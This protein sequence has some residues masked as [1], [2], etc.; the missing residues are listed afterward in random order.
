MR[1]L[2][3]LL[4]MLLALAGCG[5]E[6]AD[7]P[8][9]D[10]LVRLLDAEVR[11]LDPQKASDLA[12]LR[13]A[14]DQFEGLTRLGADGRVEAGLARQWRPS[15]DGL[16]WR[17]TLRPGLAFSDGQPITAAVFARGFARLAEGA[18]GSPHKALFGPVAAVT[19]TGDDVV[20]V[21]LNA[22]FPALP[23]LMAHPA[24]AALPLHRGEGWAGERP[25]TA[26][27]A[28]RLTRWRLND[29]LVLERNP[30]WHDGAA[31]VGHVLWRPVDDRQTAF[32]LFRAG[33]A[34]T[35]PDFPVNRLDWLKRHRPNAVRMAPYRG[36]YYFVF[37]TRRPPF[38]DARVRR[39]LNMA[40]ERERIA[41]PLLGFGA[42]PAW[43]VVPPALSRCGT[44]Y[45]PDWSGWPRAR[46]LAAAQALLRAAGYDGER[47]LRFEIRFN[48]DVDHRRVALALIDG[49]RDLPVRAS[50]LNT[51]ASLHFTSLRR[52][53]FDLARSG[54]IGDLDA[55]ENFLAIH[56]SNAGPAN[57]SGYAS[58]AFDA[59]LAAAMATADPIARAG[60]M[61]DAEAILMADAPVLP[62]HYYISRNLVA[63]TV[64]GWQDNV[65]NVH[66]S[67]T[68]RLT[69]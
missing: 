29:R 43:G 16:V 33:A 50:L 61:A 24:M 14:A 52:G 68:L 40:T 65:A 8:P 53:D 57:Y 55:P 21:R 19:A 66:P 7:T 5:R 2:L 15:A 59:A 25:L 18:T 63:E 9:P 31:P 1:P 54:W 23:E 47:P 4:L 27:G 37:N 11:S 44:G 3:P 30:R 28:Y 39:A 51:E 45:R 36:S 42:P 38:D 10:T 6:R 49:W 69:R 56:L 67:R 60:A 32:R 41:G 62:I 22:P 20:T 58:P 17:F 48:S 26:S 13:V 12:S 34:H 46:R 64:A 35:V